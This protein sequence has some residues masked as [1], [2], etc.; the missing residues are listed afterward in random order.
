[1]LQPGRLGIRRLPLRGWSRIAGT[2]P[3]TPPRRRSLRCS[4]LELSLIVL[5]LR[6]ATS[7]PGGRTGSSVDMSVRGV[8]TLPDSP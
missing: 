1:M 8:M 5:L 4:A 7:P 2:S 6:A 3:S